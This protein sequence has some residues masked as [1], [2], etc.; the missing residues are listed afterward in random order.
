MLQFDALSLRDSQELASL[1]RKAAPQARPERISL[2]V[3]AG[4]RRFFASLNGDAVTE[5]R[6]DLIS[7]ACL[8]KIFTA[9]LVTQLLADE[10]GWSD[11]DVVSFLDMESP[12]TAARL[13]GIRVG[14]L[15]SH[16]HGLD[17]SSLA[18]APRLG[19]GHIDS[20]TL[21]DALAAIEPL[22][23]PGEIY[24]YGNA[25][26]WISAAILERITQRQFSALLLDRLIE[27][28]GLSSVRGLDSET[29]PAEGTR[30]TIS[31]DDVLTFLELHMR[32]GTNS[33]DS[34]IHSFPDLASM[35]A[36]PF[37]LPGWAPAERAS[38]QGWKSYGS[39]WFGHNAIADDDSAFIRINPASQTAFVL[40]GPSARLFTISARLF[41]RVLP[42][43]TGFKLPKNLS[44]ELYDALDLGQYEGLYRTSAL[45]LEIASREKR[46]VCELTRRPGQPEASARVSLR[47]AHDNLF[48]PEEYSAAELPFLQF[49]VP[50]QEGGYRFLW[51]GKSVWRRL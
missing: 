7:V 28:L 35:R 42:E 21:C 24:S 3:L 8:M 16:T 43:F 10:S 38:C 20:E 31:I 6:D 50:R 14:H 29:C 46:L 27:P 13:R 30:V 19:S 36:A 1:L 45:T 12:V 34:S 23:G 49:V 44:P 18:A 32:S 17:A 2:G 5:T 51:N 41:S 15:L 22:A 39:G 33:P 47:A 37:P 26:S 40:A 25:G 11:R 9:T 48:L 4:G